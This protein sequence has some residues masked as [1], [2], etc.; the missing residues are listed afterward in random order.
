M[1]EVHTPEVLP[2]EMPADKLVP[3]PSSSGERRLLSFYDRFRARMVRAA[4][5]GRLPARVT[6]ILLLGPDLFMLMTRLSLDPEVPGKTRSLIGGALAYFVLPIDFMPE[7]VLGPGGFLD[8]IVLA[9]L[10]LSHVMSRELEPLTRKYWSGSEDLR[11][12]LRDVTQAADKV[13]GEGVY[14]RLQRWLG[15]RL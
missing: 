5:R 2:P 13:L 6:D 1:A 3:A 12:V 7:I 14:G 9:A 10:V 11:V 15:K 4:E 8:D